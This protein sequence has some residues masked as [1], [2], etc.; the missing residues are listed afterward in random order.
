MEH[1][2][3]SVETVWM[4]RRRFDSRYG[5]EP[6]DSFLGGSFATV[7]TGVKLSW[8]IT[9]N[10]Q[11]YFRFQMFDVINSQARRAVKKQDAY[12]AKCDWPIFKLGVE[13]SF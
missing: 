2:T 5:A 3:P 6:E 8:Q 13:Y 11:S 4:D 7:T 12:Y 10:W 1:L 9:E